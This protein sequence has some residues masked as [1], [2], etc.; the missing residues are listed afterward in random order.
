MLVNLKFSQQL[1]DVTVMYQ[2]IMAF[3]SS[4]SSPVGIYPLK[5]N[6]RNT[7]KRFEIYS[8]MFKYVTD[9][10]LVSLQSTLNI[11]SYLVLLFLLLTLNI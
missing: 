8:N 3:F 11:F 1:D 7:R 4:V 2:E 9:V 6:N 10:I 5:V